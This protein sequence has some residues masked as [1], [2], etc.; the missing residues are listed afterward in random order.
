MS[1]R[2]TR[3]QES[4]RHHDLQTQSDFSSA[5]VD[6]HCLERR[7]RL[8]TNR[9]LE[10]LSRSRGEGRDEWCAIDVERHARERTQSRDLRDAT[11]EMIARRRGALRLQR[12][13]HFLGSYY[14]VA[15]RLDLV[16]NGVDRQRPG[17]KF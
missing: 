15:R 13:L 6:R 5:E 9:Q 17:A 16:R 7:I 3:Y 12:E 14:S 11:P 8:P 10:L 2:T 4:L 1:A